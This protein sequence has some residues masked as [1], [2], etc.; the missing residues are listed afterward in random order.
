M[1]RQGAQEAPLNYLLDMAWDARTR[2]RPGVLD[3]VYPMGTM[4]VSVTGTT[5]ALKCSHCGG[6][7]LERMVDVKDMSE[8]L[9]RRKPKSILL[10]G[11]CDVSGAVPL[12]SCLAEVNRLAEDAA[13]QGRPF[14]VN[15]HP[16]IA[17]PKVARAIGEAAGVVSFDF[18]LDNEAI[19]AAFHGRWSGDDYIET[20][21]NLRKGR[22]EVVPHILVGLNRGQVDGEYRAVEFLLGEGIERLIFIVFIPTPGTL[23]ADVRPPEASCVARLMAWTRINAPGLD[24]SLGCMRPAGRYRREVDKEAVRCGVD[25]IVQPHPDALME[26]ERRGLMVLRKEECCA[27]D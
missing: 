4:P 19:R 11:G 3:A 27:F 25:R 1:N 24:I 18:V 13:A 21:R 20:F 14:R 9:V 22:A 5:C 2:G 12:S 8:E 26:A 10:S 16:G 17:P 7:Y 6:H 23:W 15:V